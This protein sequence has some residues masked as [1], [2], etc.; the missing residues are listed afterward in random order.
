MT[1]ELPRLVSSLPFLLGRGGF[2]KIFQ[3]RGGIFAGF[4]K[5]SNNFFWGGGGQKFLGGTD[6]GGKYG[7]IACHLPDYQHHPITVLPATFWLS[8]HVIILQVLLVSI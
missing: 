8:T 6:P 2:P 4:Y 3:K 5:G 7:L 1:Q